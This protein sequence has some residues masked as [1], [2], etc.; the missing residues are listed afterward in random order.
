[1]LHVSLFPDLPQAVAVELRL[2]TRWAVPFFFLVSG[3]FLAPAYVAGDAAKFLERAKRIVAILLVA[4]F[5]LAPLWMMKFGVASGLGILGSHRFFTGYYHLWFLA[6]L[7]GTLVLIWLLLRYGCRGFISKIAV[8]VTVIILL[9]AYSPNEHPY[10]YFSLYLMSF[11]LV[12]L[13]LRLG[14]PDSRLAWQAAVLL[15]VSGLL[16]QNGEAYILAKYFNRD[17]LFHDC[18]VGVVLVAIG[19]FSLSLSLP[20]G[21]VVRS[22]ARLGARH[23]LGLYLIHP[24]FIFL[25][26]SLSG[27]WSA[28]DIYIAPLSFIASLAFLIG[29]DRVFRVVVRYSNKKIA[30]N[31]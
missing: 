22:L 20:E 18:L 7:A 16:L 21:L 17:P 12:G 24:Y 2:A 14:K 15:I 23:S 27:P 11:P 9:G 5:L 31:E 4:N 1:M 8:A 26:Q 13:G 10:R 3:Y 6:S 29:F 25:F 28:S 30:S 19:V